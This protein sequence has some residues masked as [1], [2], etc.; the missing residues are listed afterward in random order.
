M[1]DTTYGCIEAGGTKFVCAV[2]R[3]PETMS[4]PTLIPT[5]DPA[6]T[7]QKVVAY[8]RQAEAAGGRLRAFGIASFGPAEVNPSSPHFGSILATPKP[9]WS[10][11]DI[12][13]TIADAF[14]VPVGFDT[15]VNGAVMAEAFWG[16]AAGVGIA[17]YVTVGTGIGAG[18]AANGRV[19]HGKRHTEAGHILPRR[20]PADSDFSGLCPFHADCLEG[21]ASGPAIERRWGKSLSRLPRDHVAHDVIGWYLAQLAVTLIATTTAES[22]MFGGGVLQTPGL[23]DRIRAAAAL[24][25]G[26]WADNAELRTM[27]RKPSLGAMSGLLGGLLLA[28]R[29]GS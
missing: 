27:I 22:V 24:N 14:Q 3:S 15:D 21:L 16:A 7:L 1:Q 13:G 17:A 29:A 4:P 2:G 26:Y 28:Q 20:H 25:A 6:S 8:F 19:I 5:A 9:G 23:L 10:N 12:R 11:V 18:V